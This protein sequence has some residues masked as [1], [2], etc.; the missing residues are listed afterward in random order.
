MLKSQT[1][2]LDMVRGRRERPLNS[3]QLLEAGR[4]YVCCRHILARLRPIENF[5]R[6]RI[7][8]PFARLIQKLKSILKIIG[9][10]LFPG[11]LLFKDS[12]SLGFHGKD[13][14]T[15]SEFV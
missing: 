6:R 4:N 14:S 11:V 3:N 7:Q 1:V 8:I 10:T 5:I 2:E 12:S 15:S 13:K 9:A